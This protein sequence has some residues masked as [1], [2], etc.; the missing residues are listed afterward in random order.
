MI[1]ALITGRL[2]RAPELKTSKNGKPYCQFLLSVPTGEER[3]LVYG[4]AFKEVAEKIARLQDGDALAVIG[5]LKPTEW[6]DKTT[7]AIKHGLSITVSN[8]LS[9]YE[10]KK[11]KPKEPGPEQS[12]P[13][14]VFGYPDQMQAKPFDDDLPF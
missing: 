11:R 4:V 12:K 8:S 3:A 5:S 13:G 10:V 1:D 7:G 6:C 14:K 2:I 9:L